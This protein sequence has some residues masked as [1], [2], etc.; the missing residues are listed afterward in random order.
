MQELSQNQWG[1]G[2]PVPVRITVDNILKVFQYRYGLR[3]DPG[4]RPSPPSSDYKIKKD[5]DLWRVWSFHG[6]KDPLP[7][8]WVPYVVDLTSRLLCKAQ[9][10]AELSS[11][12]VSLSRTLP[13]REHAA[14]QPVSRLEAGD[15]PQGQSAPRTVYMAMGSGASNF[16]WILTVSSAATAAEIS[17]RGWGP[18]KQD[19]V[20]ELVHRGIPFAILLEMQGQPSSDRKA[21]TKASSGGLGW[22]LAPFKA[23]HF[24]YALYEQYCGSFL[25]QRRYARVGLVQGGIIWRLCIQYLDPEA[26]LA[27]PVLDP[28]HQRVVTMQDRAY[29]EDV[30]SQ[31]EQDLICGVYKILNGM[32]CLL[33]CTGPH[34]LIVDLRYRSDRWQ[35]LPLAAV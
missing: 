33:L 2:R 29:V 4:Y 31:G 18:S 9:I 6:G 27:G 10:P 24:D 16:P 35:E 32:C 34:E 25:R 11:L 20:L 28:G 17:R 30:L 26:I 15:P 21:A 19:L 14:L 12:G 22:R 3:F 5:S 23:S 1:E 13:S 7:A 8:E